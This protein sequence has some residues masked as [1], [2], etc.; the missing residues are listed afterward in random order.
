[1]DQEKF[2]QFEEEILK[3]WEDKKIF[4]KSLEQRKNA[5]LFSFYDGPPFASGSPHYGHILASVIKDSI[6]RYWTMKGYKVERTVGW[7]CHGLPVENLVEKKLNIKTKKEIESLDEGKEKSIEK[8]NQACRDSIYL[9]L[10]EWLK[11]LRRIGRWADYSKQYATYK[12]EYIESVWW[13]FKQLYNKGLI[14]KDFRVAPYC[15]RCGTSISNFEVNLGYREVEDQS[16]FIKFKIKRHPEG[17]SATKGSRVNPRDCRVASGKALRNDIFDAYFLVWTT[18]PWTLPANLFLAVGEEVDYVKVKL[19]SENLILAEARLEILEGDYEI[20][21]KIKGKELLE[22]EYEP[23]FKW[24]NHKYKILAGN[25]F[26]STEDGTGIVHIAPAF[27]EIDNQIGKKENLKEFPINVDLEGKIIKGLNI[28]GEGEF[29]KKADE[30]IKKD[31]KNRGLLYKEEKITHTY[32]FCWRCDSPLLYYPLESWYIRVTALKDKLIENNLNLELKQVDGKIKKGIYWMPN[33]LKEGRFG[34][35]LEGVRDWDISRSRYWGAPIPIWECEK[36]ESVKIVGSI[37]ELGKQKPEDL[38]RPYIDQIEFTCECGGKMKRVEGVFDCWLESGSMPFAQYHYPFENKEKFEQGFPADFI[39][40]GLDQTRGWFYTLHVLAVAIFE[41]PAFKNVIVNGL[42]LA[43][44]GK[45][46]SKRLKNY[47][48]PE[49][50][51]NKYGVDA[52]RYFLLTSAPMGEDCRFSSQQVEET[53]RKIIIILWNVYTFYEM[54]GAG[55]LTTDNRQLTTPENILDQWIIAKLNLLIKE[56]TQYLDNYDLNKATRLLADFVN[57]LST[58]YL[59]R[60]RTRFKS[61]EQKERGEVSA[62]LHY[63]LLNLTKLLS[64]FIV[65]LSDVIYQKIS[66]N[67]ESVHLEDWP[68]ADE[69]LINQKLLEEMELVKEVVELGLAARAEAKIKIRQPLGN[70]QLTTYNSQ[71]NEQLINLIKDELNIKKVNLVKKIKKEGV[72][73]K[74]NNK[75]KIALETAITPELKQEGMIRELI[76]QINS[77]RKELKLTVKDSVNIYLQT[78]SKELKEAVKKY[79]SSLLKN[80]LAKEI[81]FEKKESAHQKELEIEKIKVFINIEKI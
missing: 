31:L 68:L 77:F 62:T 12:N 37:K 32:P 21:E 14:Y 57:E 18:T 53:F 8:F 35:W 27:G 23:L 54:H 45:K 76:R 3:Y 55:Q 74:E 15:P 17:I 49:E 64:P 67:K 75:I 25:D 48:P 52:L 6:T 71:L 81:K 33:H 20:I 40:E 13:A 46:L 56:T 47:T 4:A 36:C 43:A 26:V 63:V 2:S 70:L 51:F 5:P 10:D 11:T 9:C 79:Y 50:I 69:N 7:D 61:E 66:S 80:V 34:K 41:K 44:D 22:V 78:E 65:F 58:W 60:S 59:R 19:N 73:V 1:M 28:P 30:K 24:K 38:H 29:V 16:I 42:I 72:V 39:A